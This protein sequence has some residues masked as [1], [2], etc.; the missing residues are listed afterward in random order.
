MIATLRSLR[1]S[2]DGQTLVLAAIFGLILMLCVLGTVNLG[3]ALYDKVRLQAAA[4]EAAYSQAAIEARVLNY[5][6]YTNR[7]MI[8]HYAS[9]MAATSYLSWVHFMYGGFKPLLDVLQV[10]PFVAAVAKTVD[11]VLKGLV[12]LLDTAVAALVPLLSA[13]NL[14]LWAVQEGAWASVWGKLLFAPTGWPESHGGDTPAHAY[15]PIWPNV[16]PA[17]NATVF[18]QTRGQLTVPQAQAQS[19][20]LLLTSSDADVQL[21]RMQMIEIANSARQPWV[22]Y[23]DKASSPSISPLARHWRWKL[24]FG[25]GDLEVGG[26]ARTELGA[27]PPPSTS[28]VDSVANAL[29]QIWSGQRFQGKASLAGLHGNVDF[30]TFVAVD[31]M[32]PAVEPRKDAWF[33]VWDPGVVES[34]VIGI[35]LP[36]FVDA[37]SKASGAAL[38][39][40]AQRA[41]FMSPY[42]S[43]APKAR[44]TPAAGPTGDLG[45]FAQP[46]VLV[47][48][49]KEGLDYNQEAGA[50]VYGKRFSWTGHNAAG[51]GTVDFDYTDADWPQI[52]GSGDLQ[53][54]HKGL[55]AFAAA[56][57]YYHRPGEWREQPNFF[58]PLWGARLI[59]VAESNVYAKLGLQ[60]LAPL[61]QY[62]SH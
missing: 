3:R 10:I 38:P 32:S 60:K 42:V 31:Q 62:L 33:S 22:A 52:V 21:A 51:T 57:A 17:L 36:G 30:L 61:K 44:S 18:S 5:T 14:M 4:D 48:L 34:S 53:L 50:N 23:G 26:V 6:A 27:F 15:Q 13:L 56:Q 11:Q 24:S 19:A 2:E 49:A 46:D 43:F 20:K 58:N 1:E 12:A 8:V 45:N 16:I 9:I 54:F 7:A 29:P 25:I 28:K 55:N 37:L 40:P 41:F 59:P 47:G 39:V 35:V